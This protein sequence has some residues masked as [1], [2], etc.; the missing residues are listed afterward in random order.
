[1]ATCAVVKTNPLFAN[2]DESQLESL[3]ACLKAVRRVYKK[4]EFVF[5]AGERAAMVGIVLSGGVRVLMEDFDGQRTI[6]AHAGPGELFGEAFSCA[7]MEA[8]PFSIAAAEL[9]EIMLI[10]YRKIVTSCPSACAFHAR[11]IMNMLQILAEKNL[12]LTR[13]IEHLSKRT[14]R[15]KL[16]S[17]LSTQAFLAGSAVVEIPFNRRELAEYLCVDRSALSRELGAMRAEGLIRYTGRCF[18]LIRMESGR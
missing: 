6:L 17:F 2:I 10:D 18:A 4:N 13:K 1:M 9:S 14:M 8:L 16:L 3:V 7:R 11:M 12:L 15:E 5:T